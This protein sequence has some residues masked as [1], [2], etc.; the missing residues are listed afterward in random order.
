MFFLIKNK[1]LAKQARGC[2]ERPFPWWE[3]LRLVQAKCHLEKE[4]LEN[5]L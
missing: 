1:K 3:T 5:E 2:L 4:Q